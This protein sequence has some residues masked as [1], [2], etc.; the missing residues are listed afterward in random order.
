MIHD[1]D[2]LNSVAASPVARIVSQGSKV[3]TDKLD[4]CQALVAY[5]DGLLASLTASRVTE[6]KVRKAKINAKNAYIVVDYLN[7]TV[8]VSR[9]TNF[10]LD[11]G[12]ALQYTQENIVEKVFVP[13]AEPLRSEFEHFA[14][15]IRTGDPVATSGE[16]GKQALEM[17]MRISSSAL[18]TR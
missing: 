3:Y 15:C 5:E 17:C 12:Y 4:Y 10:T 2:V 9:K 7:R 13:I 1:I 16:M 11:V 18:Q 14:H 8:E 6:S